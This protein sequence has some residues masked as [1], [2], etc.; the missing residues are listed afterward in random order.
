MAEM[1]AEQ[2]KARINQLQLWYDKIIGH[3]GGNGKRSHGPPP[4]KLQSLFLADKGAWDF[5]RALMWVRV[6]DPNWMKT[7]TAKDKMAGLKALYRNVYGPNYNFNSR[8][9]QKQLTAFARSNPRVNT[10]ETLLT[11]FRKRILPSKS[12][13]KMMP[14][15]KAVFMKWLRKQPPGIDILKATDIMAQK[16]QDYKAQWDEAMTGKPIPTELLAKALSENWEANSNY[17]MKA[18]TETAEYAGTLSY[19]A[20]VEE[21][22]DRWASVFG[23]DVPPNEA[24][25]AKYAKTA[26]PW[27]TFLKTDVQKSSE[28]KNQFPDYAS[29]AAREAQQ[30]VPEADLN[31]TDFF[32]ER[33]NFSEAW[34][35]AYTNGE[36]VD[37]ELLAKAM[38]ENWS[39]PRWNNELRKLPSYSTTIEGKNKGQQFDMY[40]KS[41]FG[42]MSGVDQTLRGEFIAGDITDPSGMWDDIK[43]T[44]NF[45][46]V[47]PDW[48]AFSKAQA[49]AG[50]N[51]ISDPMAYKEYKTEFEKAFSDIGMP[52]PTGLEREIFASGVEASDIQQR[53]QQFDQ[54]KTA[55]NVQTG[56]TPDIARAVGVRGNKAVAG[57]LRE[58]MRKALEQQ[59]KLQTS[60]FTKVSEDKSTSGLVTQKI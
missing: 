2:K 29:W 60:Q 1:T 15:G 46:D 12:F 38:R 24:M 16:M 35:K 19:Q 31:I 28:F 21:F 30:G 52:V 11:I 39:M 53:A 40:W 43:Q 6:N 7:Q 26:T 56:Q 41:L 48:G 25:A 27:D 18:I 55:F 23:E 8:E 37:P 51:V 13:D 3:Y 32:A 54:T 33:T 49:D 20:R 47:F 9:M 10:R 42:E 50:N 59:R 45:R 57:D 44:Q 5:E 17:F 22:G 4:K 36:P 14:G 34:E 58:R